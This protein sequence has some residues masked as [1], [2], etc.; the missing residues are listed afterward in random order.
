M[1]SRF[2]L[3]NGTTV[4]KRAVP[5]SEMPKGVEHLPHGHDS[6][7]GEEGAELSDAERR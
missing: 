7:V 6:R 5:T 2:D 1:K 4:R 3:L